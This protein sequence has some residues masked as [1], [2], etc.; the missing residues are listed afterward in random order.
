LAAAHC[1]SGDYC[2]ASIGFAIVRDEKSNARRVLERKSANIMRSLGSLVAHF[3]SRRFGPAAW[4]LL[5]LAV[6]VMFIVG[7]LRYVEI[8]VVWRRF[9]AIRTFDLGILLSLVTIQT[10]LFALR[11]HLI[12]HHCGAGLRGRV[13]LWISVVS[14]F[15]NQTLPSTVGGDAVRIMLSRKEGAPVGRAA[16]AVLIDRGIGLV[17]LALLTGAFLPWLILLQIDPRMVRALFVVVVLQ[18]AGFTLLAFRGE[19]LLASMKKYEI[20]GHVMR[21]ARYLRRLVLSPRLF[22]GVLILSMFIHLA[23]ALMV[24]ASARAMSIPIQ[25]PTGIALT[26]PTLLIMMI[27]VS[28]AGWGVREASMIVA[29]GYAGV[30]AADAFAISVAFGLINVIAGIAGGILWLT[31]W[32]IGKTGPSPD[33]GLEISATRS[34]SSAASPTECV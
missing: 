17:A 31:G 23:S 13:T 3:R 16:S 9:F 14:L 28:I 11:W 29:L 10:L 26:L 12:A 34:G 15:F 25:V 5:R 33:T 19:A 20:V 8:D 32:G 24:V 6:T 27:P 2:T 18:L 1:D 21:L 30:G 7:I 4:L 22:A